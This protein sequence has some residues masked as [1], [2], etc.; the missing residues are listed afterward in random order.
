MSGQ[1]YSFN[2]IIQYYLHK[3][4][5][6][7]QHFLGQSIIAFQRMQAVNY[8]ASLRIFMHQGRGMQG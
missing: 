4:G 3:L 6:L 2:S 8:S 1:Y 7:Q 5:I